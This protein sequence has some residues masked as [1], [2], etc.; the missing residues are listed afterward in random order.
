[1]VNSP[2]LQT[3]CSHVQSCELGVPWAFT[4]GLLLKGG[5]VYVLEASPSLLAIL[6]TT[7][8]GHEGFQKTLQ[9]LRSDFYVPHARRAVQNFVR[10]CVICQRNKTDHLHPAGLLQPLVVPTTVWADISM[11]FIEGLPCVHGKS[12]I[13]SVIDRFSKYAHFIPLGLP[14]TATTVAR[15]FF[16]EIVRLHGIPQSIVSDRDPVF[17][18]TFGRIYSD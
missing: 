2:E 16:H 18:S 5:R 13:L 1:M 8:A 9:R 7:H 3:L 15:V 6:S 14:Y 11:D 10:A 17:T 12:V 4:D